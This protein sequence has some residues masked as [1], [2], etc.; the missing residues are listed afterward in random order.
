VNPGSVSDLRDNRV[1]ELLQPGGTEKNLVYSF[2]PRDFMAII[3][4]KEK[5]SDG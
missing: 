3:A 4:M 2:P 5:I 1:T